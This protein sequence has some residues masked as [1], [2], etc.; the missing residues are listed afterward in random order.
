[1]TNAGSSFLNLQQSSKDSEININNNINTNNNNYI[2]NTNQVEINIEENQNFL[3]Y[4]ELR[5]Q[6]LR[7]RE[8]TVQ[9]SSISM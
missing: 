4:A 2:S 3:H 1:M 5:E 6:Q 9:K 8:N 7:A